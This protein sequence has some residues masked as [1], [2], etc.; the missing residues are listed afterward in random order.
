[1]IIFIDNN[2][3]CKNNGFIIKNKLK[4]FTNKLKAAAVPLRTMVETKVNMEAQAPLK[5]SWN[6][7]AKNYDYLIQMSTFQIFNT[8]CVQTNAHSKRRI[9]EVACGSGM[10]TLYFSKTML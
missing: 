5:E 4:S 10:H 1:M 3:Y 8:L 2:Y 9:L 6:T 7:F